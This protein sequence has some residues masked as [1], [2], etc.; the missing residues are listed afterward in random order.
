MIT[1]REGVFETNSSSTHAIII[2][3]SNII[4]EFISGKHFINLATG[5]IVLEDD[6]DKE[7]EGLREYVDK[8]ID[9]DFK[10]KP[11]ELG[12]ENCNN[13]WGFVA[14]HDRVLDFYHDSCYNDMAISENDCDRLSSG[15]NI[16]YDSD[17]RSQYIDNYLKLAFIRFA[18]MN[19]DCDLTY[20]HDTIFRDNNGVSYDVISVSGSDSY[21]FGEWPIR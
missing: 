3:K 16:K 7:R 10:A 2:N 6:V 12:I 17:V 14:C 18:E 13:R 15:T 21:S 8:F 1:I 4:S 11:D 5:E 19:E 9:S 20:D